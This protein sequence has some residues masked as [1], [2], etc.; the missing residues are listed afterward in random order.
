MKRL[1]Y[2]LTFAL[3]FCMAQA[4]KQESIDI[5][6]NGQKRNMVVFTPNVKSENM[7]LMIVTHGMNQSPEY[8]YDSDKFYN[9]IDTA[10][11]V[12]TYL[13]S[14]G[15]TWDTG[16]T[17]DQN[18]VLQTIDEMVTRYGINRNRVYW[19]GFSMGSMLIYHCMANVQDKFAAFAPTS[20]IQFSEQPW[21][22]CKQPVNLI[23]CHAYGDDVFGYEQ[24]G[25]RDY[26][27]NMAKM[28]DFTTYIKLANY[29]VYANCWYNG[30]KEVWSSDKNGHVVE[31][32]SYN[33]G[34]HWP[35][36]DNAREI[37]NFCKRFSL[38]TV[39]EEFLEVYNYAQKLI[40]EWKDTP[41]MT[42]RAVYKTLQK[43]LDTYAPEKMTSESSM[44]KATTKLN[45]YISVFERAAAN[46]EKKTEGGEIDQPEG[47]DPNFHIY[48]CFGQ[49]NMEGN[50]KIE[51]Q[52][53]TGIDPR[54]K[55]MAAVDM[56]SSS[57]K[58][59]EWYTAY[60]PLCRDWT[61][62]TP[63]DYFGRTMVEN[64]PDSISVG[65][66]NVAVGGCA[67]ELFDEDQCAEYIKNAA[68]WLK[69]YCA[70]YN[71]NPYRTLIDL[72]KKA[73]KVG[74]IKGILLH[75]GCSNNGQ[76]DW[77]VKVKRVYIRMLNELGLNEEE[78]P[79]L[80]G[81][82][83]SQ[84]MGGVC[85]GHNSV[86][87]NTYTVIPNSHVISSA[88]CPG[89][90]DGL[91]FTAEGYRMIGKRYAETMLKLLGTKKQIDFD[92]SE[93]IFP[94][95]SD[96]FNPS[97]FLQGTF[98]KGT[99][100]SSFTSSQEGNFGG[101]RYSKGID[102]SD[103][104]YLVVKLMRAANK[105][106]V[107]IF[108]TDDYLNP[109]YSCEMGTSK[110][111]SIDLHDMKT[112]DGKPIDPSHIY[113]VGIEMPSKQSLYINSIYLSVDGESP[114][115]GIEAIQYEPAGM[116]GNDFYDLTGR[117]VMKPTRGIYIQHGR[118]V[119]VK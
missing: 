61:G 24:Y 105:P 118:K 111:V 79:L 89:A 16:G 50:A 5:T 90:S 8:Q 42:S 59:G 66:I 18:F 25:I 2:F 87:A 74:V 20:G 102:L 109:C 47:F 7:P 21:N 33:N 88:N 104:N 62:L 48:L 30:D 14:D 94:L 13:R 76:Q 40:D 112:P 119:L 35:M 77:P 115:T 29:K 27:Q 113:M 43:A 114:A 67:I 73:Q 23:H 55:M 37:W 11:F 17:K 69:G 49:S 86:I 22:A 64:L 10:K 38:Q 91:H 83:L 56:P 58:K 99:K 93:N 6:V 36:E 107:K 31:L 44:E 12:V 1:F 98:K 70:E 68:D 4:Y 53:R 60:P 72:A 3:C 110:T 75:Q 45:A 26:V 71:N 96:A 97:L 28:N 65:I 117:K 39:E 82:L 78:T 108:D 85:W 52:D 81:E 32:F 9:L 84:K 80:I 57:R 106:V 46:I 19:S 63:A 54:F 95:T 34:G 103:Y 41:E 51:A 116:K 100:F 101:W 92:T 15:N